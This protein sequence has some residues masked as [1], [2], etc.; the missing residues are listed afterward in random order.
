MIDAAALETSRNVSESGKPIGKPNAVRNLFTRFKY[1][2]MMLSIPLT[3]VTYVIDNVAHQIASFRV[4]DFVSKLMT[5]HPE[6]LFGGYGF[7]DVSLI[8]LNNLAYW[9]FYRF[10]H[11]E[12]L[13]DSA[14]HNYF[15]TV[16]FWII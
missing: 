10:Y 4:V 7:Q 9:T 6:L 12:H 13:V 3:V 15:T 5:S 2:G 16:S 8:R 11:P 1:F 14:L